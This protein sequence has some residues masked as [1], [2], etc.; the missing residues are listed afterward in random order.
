L[1][2]HYAFSPIIEGK[3]AEEV[4]T[5]AE[6]LAEKEMERIKGRSYEILDITPVEPNK[7]R[8][9]IDILR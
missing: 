6:T 5:K 4:M 2:E 9:T 1:A 3:D 8:V 7:Y